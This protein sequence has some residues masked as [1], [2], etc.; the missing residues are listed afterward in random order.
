MIPYRVSVED[1]LQTKTVPEFLKA[2]IESRRQKNP[3]LGVRSLA[4]SLRSTP[5]TLSNILNRKR[6]ASSRFLKRL[7]VKMD[8][9][10]QLKKHL[11]LI[12]EWE[13]AQTIDEKG[14][15]SEKIE[16]NRSKRRNLFKIDHKI[17]VTQEQISLLQTQI[18]TLLAAYQKADTEGAATITIRVDRSALE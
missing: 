13:E 18:T 7:A 3:R 16:I 15:I 6:R 12:H 9:S 10:S 5:G 4:R 2:W 11:I 1:L 17:W 14:V 8:L